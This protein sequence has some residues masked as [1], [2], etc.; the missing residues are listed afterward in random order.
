M[1][2]PD[3]D[4]VTVPPDRRPLDEQPKWRKDF[5]IDWPQDEYVSRR[6]LIK[7]IIL[8]SAAFVA[9]QF[10]LVF[11]RFFGDDGVGEDAKAIAQVDELEVGSTKMFEYP[12]GSSPRLLIRLG[13]DHFV[14]YD[15]QCTHLLCPVLPELEEGKLRCPCHNGWFEA[16]TGR[17][18][19][20]PPP[21]PLARVELTIENGTVFAT[22]I[23][24]RTV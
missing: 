6:D 19:S 23:E 21:R 24:R 12:D 2:T 13:E 14:A 17:V 11:E 9:G 16:E 15:Q 4:Q 5:P 18:L 1:Q 3:R 8:T 7:F 22:G 10:A 20:G